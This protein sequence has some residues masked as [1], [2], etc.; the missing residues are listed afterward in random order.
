M[1]F[2]RRHIG[3]VATGLATAALMTGLPTTTAHA[4]DQVDV[5]RAVDGI[6]EALLKADASALKD[7][8]ADQLDYGH[9]NGKLDTKNDFL[10][11]VANK[12]PVY[13]TIN[14]E[15]RKT[16]IVGST[17]IVR[18]NLTAE[19]ETDGK[20]SSVKAGVMQIWTKQDGK[21]RLLARQSYRLS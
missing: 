10:A 14:L 11:S 17:A 18:Y 15:D 9:S 8:L 19:I 3:A 12:K 20:V 1:L 2:S 7:L 6:R 13:K 21:W 16:T 4:D 5:N